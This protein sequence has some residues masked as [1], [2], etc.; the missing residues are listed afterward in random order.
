[1]SFKA[2]QPT[3]TV[4]EFQRPT[5]PS[6]SAFGLNA[7]P[8]NGGFSLTED[9]LQI[10]DRQAAEQV[11]RDLI[12]SLGLAGTG[13]DPYAQ[14]LSDEAL[15]YAQPKLE[16]SLIQRGLGG[17]SV[18]G[19]AISNL[20][21]R[22]GIEGVLGSNQ[23]RLQNLQGLQSSYFGPYM[24]LG[25]NLLNLSASTGLKQEQLAQQLYQNLLPYITQVNYPG[26]NG[27]EGLVSGGIQGFATGGLPGA[28][29]GAGTGYTVGRQDPYSSPLILTDYYKNRGAGGG[30]SLQ[31][32]LNLQGA[33]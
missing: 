5:P 28:I 33:F 10:A 26:S 16:N 6:F 1:M 23:A 30:L 9:P 11:R 32:L 14:L 17:S 18:Y 22:A 12:N 21:S 15:R 24:N 27:L 4:P 25:Q 7:G 3:V 2:K 8:E 29:A 20:I 13:Q 19:D 31:N